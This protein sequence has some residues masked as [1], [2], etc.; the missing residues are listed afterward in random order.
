LDL[1]D[2]ILSVHL[3]KELGLTFSFVHPLFHQAVYQQMSQTRQRYLHGQVA[4]TLEDL[5]HDDAALPVEAI[6]DH[7]LRSDNAKP[8]ITYL[9]MAG[10]RA[11]AL[12]AHEIA[13]NYYEQAL[14]LDDGA[15]AV[16]LHESLGDQ[17]GMLGKE[18]ESA[19]HFEAA[20]SGSAMADVRR[21]R[22]KAAYRFTLAG[23]LESAWRHLSEAMALTPE[24]RDLEWVRLQYTLAHYH[25]QR[26]D[27]DEALKIAQQSL[28]VAEALGAQADAAKAYEMM[29]LCCVPLGEW[30]HGLEYEA[31]RL[32][33]VDLNRYLADV[34][35]VH[36]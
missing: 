27:F 22:R 28:S 15:Y 36:L 5:C 6:A 21:L 9:I 23:N 8:A 19:A 33:R 16:K 7:Y 30:R 4:K 32:S 24:N 17:L 1:L 26:N 34:S 12:Y 3:L 29:A 35:D 18:Q 20:I 10:D 13:I 14:K 31:Q 25:W 2:E 11:A